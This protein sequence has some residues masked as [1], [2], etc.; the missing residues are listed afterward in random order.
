MLPGGTQHSHINAAEYSYSHHMQPQQQQQQQQQAQQQQQ[1]Q[2]MFKSPLP[3]PAVSAPE[4]SP[5]QQQS[6]FTMTPMSSPHNSNEQQSPVAASPVHTSVPCRV[7]TY[8]GSDNTST[9]M[10]LASP[11]NLPATSAAN[12]NGSLTN[13]SNGTTVQSR[14]KNMIMSRQGSN[15][16]Q[17]SASAFSPGPGLTDSPPLGELRFSGS[18]AAVTSVASSPDASQVQESFKMAQ[19]FLAYR[20]TEPDP[21]SVVQQTPSGDKGIEDLNQISNIKEGLLSTINTYNETKDE[22]LTNSQVQN[23]PLQEN[24]KTNPDTEGEKETSTNVV[25]QKNTIPNK[26]QNFARQPEEALE[27]LFKGS[28]DNEMEQLLTGENQQ[29]SNIGNQGN[30]SFSKENETIQHSNLSPSSVPSSSQ[31]GFSH[32]SSPMITTSITSV[33]TDCQSSN[34]LNSTMTSPSGSQNKNLS[35]YDFPDSPDQQLSTKR[36]C[37]GFRLGRVRG[38]GAPSVGAHHRLVCSSA[39][40]SAIMRPEVPQNLDE[41]I[42]EESGNIHIKDPLP[43]P[44]LSSAPAKSPHNESSYSLMPYTQTPPSVSA[45]AIQH[46]ES[47]TTLS[48]SQILSSLSS[49]VHP[50]SHSVASVSSVAT[51][52]CSSAQSNF[53]SSSSLSLTSLPSNVVQHSPF[54]FK[55]N[56]IRHPHSHMYQQNFLPASQYQNLM[57]HPQ[58]MPPMHNSFPPNMT[59]GHIPNMQMGQ[60]MPQGNCPANAYMAP[61]PKAKTMPLTPQLSQN[62]LSQ[63][64][65][66]SPSPNNTSTTVTT[67]SLSIPVQS[68]QASSQTMPL[69]SPQ[70]LPLQSPQTP[71]NLPL[72]SPQTPQ[73]LPLQSPQAASMHSPQTLQKSQSLPVSSPPN[74]MHSP[75]MSQMQNVPSSVPHASPLGSNVSVMSNHASVNPSQSSL[76]NMPSALVPNASPS[77]VDNSSSPLVEN[78][79]PS[80]NHTPSNILPNSGH[81][82]ATNPQHINSSATSN[83]H[84][85]ILHASAPHPQQ[86]HSL[87]QNPYS[88]YSYSPMNQN[89]VPQFQH[90]MNPHM[91]PNQFSFNSQ[92]KSMGMPHNMMQPCLPSDPKA[93][94]PAPKKAASRKRGGLTKKQKQQQ[95]RQ[96][97]EEAEKLKFQEMQLEKQHKEEMEKL[98][99]QELQQQHQFPHQ[100]H[101]QPFGHNK[102]SQ[103]ISPSHQ[104]TQPMQHEYLPQQQWGTPRFPMTQYHARPQNTNQLMQPPHPV[105][106]Q[107]KSTKSNSS[108][109]KG[110]SNAKNNNNKDSSLQPKDQ[111]FIPNFNHTE[112]FSHSPMY[113][114]QQHMLQKNETQMFPNQ[115]AF[116]GQPRIMMDGFPL[117]AP[118]LQSQQNYLGYHKSS[119]EKSMQGVIPSLINNSISNSDPMIFNQPDG[120]IKLNMNSNSQ[121]VLQQ[122]DKPYLGLQMVSPNEKNS[123]A[124]S[125]HGT[126]LASQSTVAANMSLI[127][128]DNQFA[129]A[130]DQKPNIGSHQ[131]ESSNQNSDTAKPQPHTAETASYI[132]SSSQNSMNIKQEPHYNTVPGAVAQSPMDGQTSLNQSNEHKTIF[133]HSHLP[134]PVN[135]SAAATQISSLSTINT[136][137]LNSIAETGHEQQKPN[138]FNIKTEVTD[139]F[140]PLASSITK[141]E[142]HRQKIR[143]NE[144]I[145]PKC[146]CSIPPGKNLL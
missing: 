112:S 128:P 9:T 55:N 18:V 142:D 2:N 94:K 29:Q 11:N 37:S 65:L 68:P 140:S 122:Y 70:N 136:E 125:G 138:F 48:S 98:R 66:S 92:V 88:S 79:A 95:E 43:H 31:S 1:Q 30:N 133:P 46:S 144:M 40:S 74:T 134:I 52:S 131:I 54:P 120:Q 83:H 89:F 7:P 21:G 45:V 12:T 110:A 145:V 3:S 106:K 61:L 127:K 35:I 85:P 69:L 59:P 107:T 27:E 22:N 36:R 143:M 38:T 113:S 80:V 130:I 41:G 126:N 16:S 25:D 84:P 119:P 100:Q 115:A 141:D 86:G 135:V 49:M 72:A 108:K 42:S 118:N 123:N 75:S 124:V 32:M 20:T 57:H 60:S 34:M 63:T 96:Q 33:S 24:D 97:R 58:N 77:L 78:C 129:Q 6:G 91:M 56:Y 8:H 47:L 71:Q 73:N 44:S 53:T 23:E 105:N 121:N 87:P 4:A 137:A 39:S 93:R 5:V 90:P 81:S 10:P 111:A 51:N 62:S 26:E 15:G 139:E 104:M 99:F 17:G 114:Q 14:L 76:T 109:K 82:I 13:N 102:S 146:S 50:G 101:M 103:F 19:N 28:V 67:T 117:N 116:M 132:G 64:P